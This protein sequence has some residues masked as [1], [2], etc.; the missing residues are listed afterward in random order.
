MTHVLKPA[1]VEAGLGKWVQ[2]REFGRKRGRRRAETW[3][4]FHTLRH[5]CESILFRHG[6]SPK[7]VQVWLG[8]HSPAFTLATYVHLMPEDLPVPVF[9]DALTREG[10]NEAATGDP[11]TTGN[12]ATAEDAQTRVSPE[13]RKRLEAVAAFS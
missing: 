13:D 3:V 4:G 11:E 7:V 2:E 5:T 8:H 12:V 1:A 9:F 10:G 6:A